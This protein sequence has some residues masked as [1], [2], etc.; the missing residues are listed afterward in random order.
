MKPATKIVLISAAALAAVLLLTWVGGLFYW[1]VRIRAAIQSWEQAFPGA[2]SNPST[3]PIHPM[4]RGLSREDATVIL[5]AGCRAL[6][7]LVKA[8]EE[9]PDPEFQEGVMARIISCLSGPGPYTETTFAVMKER[10]IEW[11]F[12]GSGLA[13][14][15]TEKMAKFREWWTQNGTR[16][17]R[18]WKF[19]SAWCYVD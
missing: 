2:S 8:M 1:H 17:H 15:R 3:V 16:Y 14:E 12:L 18:P 19:W 6:P 9:S 11:Q 13:F 4:H 10:D 5:E 7:H